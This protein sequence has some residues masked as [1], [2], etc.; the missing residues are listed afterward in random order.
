MVV[1]R[2]ASR[3]RIPR[4]DEL[5]ARAPVGSRGVARPFGDPGHEPVVFIGRDFALCRV[6]VIHNFHRA[7]AR[8]AHERDPSHGGAFVRLVA[9]H[10]DG[11]P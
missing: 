5:P 4:A 3:R 11:T 2:C 1:V 8:L 7:R 10:Y 9:M 6:R